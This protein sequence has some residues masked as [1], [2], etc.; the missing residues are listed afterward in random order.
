MT[1]N[2]LIKHL[3]NYS[4]EMKEKEIRIVCPNGL[5]VDPMIKFVLKDKSQIFN[6][7]CDNIKTIVF[8]WEQ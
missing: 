7:G 5:L 6:Y 2:D 1:V 4:D 3:E 8:T